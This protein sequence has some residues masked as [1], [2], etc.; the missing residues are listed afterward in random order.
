M[1]HKSLL[2]VLVLLLSMLLSACKD[3]A[4]DAGKDPKEFLPEFGDKYKEIDAD[5]L[6]EGMAAAGIAMTIFNPAVS[7]QILAIDGILTCTNS[8]GATGHQIY[9]NNSNP[10]FAGAVLIVN[11]SRV[12]SLN[13]LQQCVLGIGDGNEGFADTP[14]PCTAN[15]E[16]TEDDVK[17][18]ILYAA[19]DTSVCADFSSQLPGAPAKT[20]R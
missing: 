12:K 16:Y 18:Y 9:I 14:E 17:Y 10:A 13:T 19:T 15:W 1:M 6:S 11:E 2:L 7:A 4:K 5:S 20:G 8:V 3:E